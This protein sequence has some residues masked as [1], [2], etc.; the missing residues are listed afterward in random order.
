MRRG[1]TLLELILY[2][3]I[4]AILISTVL[5]FA[6]NLIQSRV[7]NQAI[8]EVEG[9]GSEAIRVIT[10]GLRNAEGIVW[11]VPGSSSNFVQIDAVGTAMDP[12]VYF[13]SGDTL[14]I[15]DQIVPSRPLTSARVV[16]SDA[17]FENLS[18]SDTPGIV[19]FQ[20]TLSYVNPENRNEYEYSKT[21]YGSGS[22]R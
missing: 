14:W 9:Q 7:K 20:F 13:H 1:F 16:V 10:Q 19:R 8:F 5:V 18:R 3:G 11:P 22:L 12:T 17:I 6:I 15:W 21:F 4:A 2:V